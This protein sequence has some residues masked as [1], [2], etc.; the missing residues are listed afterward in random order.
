MENKN[1]LLISYGI[2]YGN[3]GRGFLTLPWLVI[4]MRMLA[5]NYEKSIK[6][7]DVFLINHYL[8][9]LR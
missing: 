3:Q 2:L 7:H 6:M 5:R 4:G 1:I 8:E 9:Q